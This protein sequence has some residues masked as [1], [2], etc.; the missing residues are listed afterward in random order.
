MGEDKALLRYHSLPQVHWM[1]DMMAR[2]AP[3]VCVSARR[4]QARLPG[5]LGLTIIC[6]EVEGI[7]PLAGLLAAFAHNPAAAWLVTAVD[8]PWITAATLQRLVDARDPAMHATA[9]RNPWT[10]T[11]EPMCA[12]YE[13]AILPVLLRARE[14][15]R[16]SLM[17]LRDVPVALVEPADKRELMGINSQEEYRA[18]WE[19]GDTEDP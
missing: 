2:V 8:M 11:P 17:L 9:Y 19:P 18:S 7:G 10:D 6:D 4:D 1:A 14:A 13:P 15:R 3:P 12:I 5:F 16:Y